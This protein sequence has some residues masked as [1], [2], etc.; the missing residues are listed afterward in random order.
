VANH[1]ESLS[2]DSV[3]KPPEAQAGAYADVGNAVPWVSPAGEARVERRRNPGRDR[4]MAMAPWFRSR[5]ARATK[6]LPH[7]F[8]DAGDLGEDVANFRLGNDQRRGDRNRV[9]SGADQQAVVME[10]LFHCL[11]GALAEGV[12]F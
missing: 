1:D 11:E 8:D 7:R 3:R 6:P 5:P 2:R 4:S 10:G 9:P 12:G